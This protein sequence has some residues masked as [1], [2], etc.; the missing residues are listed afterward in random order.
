MA[1]TAEPG[2]IVHEPVTRHAATL[3][4]YGEFDRDN[5]ERLATA[6]G[7]ELVAGRREITLDLRH[8]V[9]IDA[10][11]TA[12]LIACRA[13]IGAEG[14]GLR[15][16][17]ARGI[18]ARVLDLTE[19][20]HVRG[21]AGDYEPRPRRLIP[22]SLAFAALETVATSARLIAQARELLAETYTLLEAV[23]RP[24]GVSSSPAPGRGPGAASPPDR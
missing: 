19:I 2:V 16:V 15:I 22:G 18:V 1:A 12:T 17:N 3:H 11:T 7:L 23:R 21:P 5:R 6:V 24:A 20:P 10:A 9:F 8:L 4:A 13:R 14:A